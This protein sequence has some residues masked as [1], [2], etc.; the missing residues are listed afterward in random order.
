M[1]DSL[2][3]LVFLLNFS[4]QRQRGA[5]ARAQIDKKKE[6]DIVNPQ[7]LITTRHALLL[8]FDSWFRRFL[9]VRL[10]R[11]FNFFRKFRAFFG[12]WARR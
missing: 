5:K 10:S 7:T 1:E 8:V 12:S 4:A 9:L 3:L 11:L 2:I 6:T